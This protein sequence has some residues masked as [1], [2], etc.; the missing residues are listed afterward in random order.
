MYIGRLER[1]IWLSMSNSR[2]T[3]VSL[4]MTPTVWGEARAGALSV[5][6]QTWLEL[7]DIYV[8]CGLEDVSRLQPRYWSQQNLILNYLC[9]ISLSSYIN[10]DLITLSVWKLMA[11]LCHSHPILSPIRFSFYWANSIPFY[12]HLWH[13]FLPFCPPTEHVSNVQHCSE[14]HNSTR[15]SLL[16][17]YTFQLATTCW[18]TNLH[19]SN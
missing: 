13:P 4:I 9:Y 14:F 7:V 17:R 10:K 19:S 18:N 5:T 15:S 1:Q 12:P 16:G 2:K 8:D 3:R 11:L 6:S